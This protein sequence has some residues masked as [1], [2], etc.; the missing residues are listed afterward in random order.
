MIL[1]ILEDDSEDF[2]DWQDLK[3]CEGRG[4]V[5]TKGRIT[6]CSSSICGIIPLFY[7]NVKNSNYYRSFM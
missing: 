4:G 3:R 7:S 1:K 6:E 5:S 2:E